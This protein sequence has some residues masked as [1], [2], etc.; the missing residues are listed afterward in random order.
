MINL[1]KITQDSFIDELQKIADK[2]SFSKQSV[3][4]E[5][6]ES[7]AE[8]KEEESEAS[9]ASTEKITQAFA[10]FLLKN[11]D[12]NITDDDVH[13]WAEDNKYK[14]PLVE[15]IAYSFAKKMIVLLNDGKAKEKGL[16]ED[17]VDAE[18]L[19]KGIEVEKEHSSDLDIQKK[20]AMDH[21]A[22]F[23]KYYDALDE[24]ETKLKANKK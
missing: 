6:T 3:E 15:S 23:P 4:D 17:Q 9:N 5:H 18:Q 16:T 24:M 7:E 10:S 1:E 2:E 13:K 21:L 20:T 19:K 22:E 8:K 11:K 14:T 12:K